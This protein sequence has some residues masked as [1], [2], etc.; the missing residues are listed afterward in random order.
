MAKRVVVIGSGT[1]GICAA[2]T[3]RDF[4]LD[5]VVYEQSDKIGGTWNYTDRVGPDEYGLNYG[6]MYQDLIT[7]VPKARGP[8]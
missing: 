8:A 5:V 1:A 3:A 7:N 4:G 2:K 6:Y